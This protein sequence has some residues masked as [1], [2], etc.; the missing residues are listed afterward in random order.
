M[1]MIASERVIDSNLLG[2]LWSCSRLRLLPEFAETQLRDGQR[3][4]PDN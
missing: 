2:L 4:E 1:T 3:H